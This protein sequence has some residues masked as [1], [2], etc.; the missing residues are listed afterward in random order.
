M[1]N[2]EV[3]DERGKPRVDRA[4]DERIEGRGEIDW[5]MG[6]ALEVQR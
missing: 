2:V 1:V 6:E 3:V 4:F 5:Q